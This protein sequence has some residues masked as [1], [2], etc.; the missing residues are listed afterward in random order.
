LGTK[1]DARQWK[2]V[3]EGFE[4]DFPLPLSPTY[5]FSNHDRKRSMAIARNDVRIMRLM[6]M[7]QMTVRGIPFTYY[8]EELGIPKPTLPM[9]TGLDPLAQQYRAIPQFMVNWSGESLNRDECRT[10]MLWDT[11]AHAGFT[12]GA[13]WLPVSPD[14]PMIN[15]ATQQGDDHSLMRFYARLLAL[16]NASEALRHGT[17]TIS[18]IRCDRDV[19]AYYRTLGEETF[20]ILLNF[21]KRDKTIIPPPGQLELSTVHSP[22][23]RALAPWDGR[24]IRLE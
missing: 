3:I 14:H 4:R 12:T 23:Q 1:P 18:D 8:G 10:P 21:S 11:T 9:R 20:L 7:L 22:R 19:L 15:A 13:P 2:H 17:L 16:R 6:A 24:A 5:V